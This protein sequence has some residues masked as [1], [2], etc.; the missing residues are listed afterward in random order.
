MIE[1]LRHL[2]NTKSS[3]GVTHQRSE[4]QLQS[5]D[6]KTAIAPPPRQAN[7][8]GFIETVT[9][10]AFQTKEDPCCSRPNPSFGR[11]RRE[12]TNQN[13]SVKIATPTHRQ[14]AQ[15]FNPRG[16]LR[17]DLRS[18]HRKL[19]KC[20]CALLPLILL[21]KPTTTW[22]VNLLCQPVNRFADVQIMQLLEHVVMH[23][24]KQSNLPANQ[25]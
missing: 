2:S 23:T 3:N 7:A 16:N 10:A 9:H 11:A 14:L 18:A 24:T 19:S 13:R 12:P 17:C 22:F 1:R 25:H 5:P 8:N 4:Q 21:Y 6:H 15:A 20:S